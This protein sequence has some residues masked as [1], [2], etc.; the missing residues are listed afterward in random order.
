M[1]AM[2]IDL[3]RL[4]MPTV[5]PDGIAAMELIA[6]D[7][8]SLPELS[9]IISRDPALSATLLKYA[10]SPMY[11]S[12]TEITNVNRAISVLGAKALRAAIMVATMRGFTKPDDTSQLLW[13]HSQAVSLIAKL[14]AKRHFPHLAD[15]IELAALIH[16]MGALVLASNYPDQYGKIVQTAISIDNTSTLSQLEN[17]TFG[18]IH[19][20]VTASFITSCRLPEI[21][22]QIL[23]DFHHRAPF[24][25]TSDIIQQ[26]TAIISLAHLLEEQINS[27]NARLNEV[28]PESLESLQ[29][30][31]G[32]TEDDVENFIED[33]DEICLS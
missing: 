21:T 31:L 2:S 30:H 23:A 3:S 10:N 16:D 4:K 14:I 6:S 13:E 33:Y 20:E 12:A 19:D 27:H 15:D 1:N 7:D 29:I 24:I 9:D 8:Y 17:E 26:Q 28:I 25:E 18:V 32:L 22:G 11:S 5:S